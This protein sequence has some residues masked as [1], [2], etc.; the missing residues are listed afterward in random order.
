MHAA[1]SKQKELRSRFLLLPLV[2]AFTCCRSGSA[3]VVSFC[4]Y[5]ML[6]L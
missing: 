2:Q 3:A 6:S 1:Q 4:G 5:V